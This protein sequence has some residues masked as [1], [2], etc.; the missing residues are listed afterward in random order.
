MTVKAT[1]RFAVCGQNVV[2]E[3]FLVKSIVVLGK[4]KIMSCTARSSL[5]LSHLV[6]KGTILPC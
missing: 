4:V 1:G 3:D 5:K 2:F 6:T